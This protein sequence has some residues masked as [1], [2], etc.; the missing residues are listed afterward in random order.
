MGGAV[1]KPAIDR[2]RLLPLMQDICLLAALAFMPPDGRFRVAIL[3]SAAR[4]AFLP[5]AVKRIREGADSISLF[6]LGGQNKGK[7]GCRR[8][9]SVKPKN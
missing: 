6:C 5:P 2:L 7:F 4:L 1:L 3:L 8:R 9:V